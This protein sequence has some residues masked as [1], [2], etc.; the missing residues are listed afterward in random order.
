MSTRFEDKDPADVVVVEFDFTADTASISADPAPIVTATTAAGTDPTPGSVLLGSPE[1][2]GTKIRHRVTGGVHGADYALRCIVASGQ[3]RLVIEAILP[4]RHRP[5]TVAA[6]PIYC[7][8]A[9]FEQRFGER[10]LTDLLAGGTS[11]TRAENDAA[12]TIDGFLSARYATPLATPP[13]VVIGWAADIARYRLW[14]QGAPEEVRRRYEDAI[15]QL[16][17]LARGLIHL[18]AAAGGA[19]PTSAGISFET[20]SAPRVFDAAGLADF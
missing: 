14:D 9:E 17:D 7:T 18:P 5:T 16:R 19:T 13:A 20:F 10:E 6:A 2:V 3:D 11:Y 8:E 4:V 15:S 12:S 1:I